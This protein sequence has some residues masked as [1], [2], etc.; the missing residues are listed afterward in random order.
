[1]SHISYAMIVHAATG[2]IVYKTR[3]KSGGNVEPAIKTGTQQPFDDVCYVGDTLQPDYLVGK[4]TLDD[5]DGIDYATQRFDI[6]AQALR[7]ATADEIAAY[8]EVIKTADA[9]SDVNGNK[10]LVALIDVVADLHNMTASDVKD[11][12]VAKLKD[13]ADA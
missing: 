5:H 3:N 8:R 10:T 11:L 9:N 2:R 6:N 13:S 1:M 4:V 7:A 12:V